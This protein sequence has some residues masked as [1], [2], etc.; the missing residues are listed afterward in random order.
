MKC[1][2]GAA[3]AAL[4][5]LPGAQVLVEGNPAAV[6]QDSRALVNVPAFGMCSTLSNPSVASATSAAN[7]VLTPQPCV[8]QPQPWVPG[9]PLVLVGGVPAVNGSCTLTCAFGGAITVTNPGSRQ[10]LG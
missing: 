2:F 7:G 4:T 8:P 1:S 5:V 3:P 6:I 9:I 10:T